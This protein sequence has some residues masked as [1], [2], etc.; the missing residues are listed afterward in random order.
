VIRNEGV[1]TNGQKSSDCIFHPADAPSVSVALRVLERQSVT[2]AHM[3]MFLF[4]SN[5]QAPQPFPLG[6]PL[7]VD[8]GDRCYLS[9]GP[10]SDSVAFVRNNVFVF[11]SAADYSVIDFAE[12]LDSQLVA[13][14]FTA[15]TLLQPVINDRTFHFS[16]AT[17][18]GTSYVVEFNGSPGGTN[19][20]ASPPFTG[21]GKIMRVAFPL[22][23]AQRQFFR[24]HSQ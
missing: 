8:V 15:P 14:S 2:N 11:L 18:S 10:V 1:W 6:P 4:F 24:V 19:W 5:S 21:D 22:S 9:W 23:P 3:A 13:S 12:K 16:L 20:S 17:V 7:G